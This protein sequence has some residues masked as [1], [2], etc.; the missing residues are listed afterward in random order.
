MKCPVCT[1]ELTTAGCP[2]FHNA[3]HNV[4]LKGRSIDTV[5]VDGDFPVL[6]V[7]KLEEKVK[8]LERIVKK[9]EDACPNY[10]RSE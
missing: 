5:I 7:I 3:G 8:K 9:L 6:D 4:V 1:A 2:N 10:W